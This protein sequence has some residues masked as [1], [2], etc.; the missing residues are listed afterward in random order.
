M[1]DDK[2]KD[3]KIKKEKEKSKSDISCKIVE[4]PVRY[5]V[6]SCGCYPTSCCCC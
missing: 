3:K 1:E 2:N 4:E 6:S 5:Y